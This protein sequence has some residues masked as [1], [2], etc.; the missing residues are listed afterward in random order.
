MV[1]TITVFFGGLALRAVGQVSDWMDRDYLNCP[2]FIRRFRNLVSV[3]IILANILV[4]AS[5]ACRWVVSI[6]LARRSSDTLGYVHGGRHI[7]N[8]SSREQQ[9]RRLCCK[10]VY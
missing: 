10:P 4:L 6:P 2:L 3:Q 8:I 7:F 1:L 5:A 9:T